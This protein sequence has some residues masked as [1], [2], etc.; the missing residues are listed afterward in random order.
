[1]KLPKTAILML[2]G[3]EG[4]GVSTYARHFKAYFDSKNAKCDIFALNLKIGRPDTSTDIDVEIF[5]FCEAAEMVRRI[6]KDYD[7][8]LVFS[9]PSKSAPKVIVENYVEFLLEP[10]T[11][12]KWMIN[13]DHHFLSIS[14]NADYA[15][16][17]ETCDGLLCH[18]LTETKSGFIS[19]LK[20]RNISKVAKKMDVF[21]HVPF[22]NHLIDLDRGEKRQKR[23][24]NAARAVAWKRGSVVLNLHNALADRGFVTEM[25]G[26]ER[27]IAGYSQLKNYEGKLKWFTDS[28]FYKPI[29]G[30]SA[31]SSARI[32]NELFDHIDQVGQNPDFMYVI[33]S[34]DYERGLQ[35]IS[36]SA[37]ATHPRSFEH[38]N[39]DYGNNFE[40]QGLEAALLAVPIFHRHFLDTVVL[41]DG[42]GTLAQTG[43]FLSVDDDN[44]HLTKGGPQV[45]GVEEFAGRLDEIWNDFSEYHRMR[46][47]SVDLVRSYY[48][49]D[50]V[51]P[52]LLAALS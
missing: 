43:V 8:V 25:I 9:V 14:R 28:S 3:V 39:L 26:F 30:P 23:L 33:G 7:L 32:N 4:C 5:A 38:N 15:N 46:K 34:Y 12:P 6:N 47:N 31:F 16:A 21:F 11:V 2:R 10:I 29:K 40:Y 49:S 18:S 13:H 42:S 24:I 22:V 52:K 20:K 19:W 51:V 35:R 36:E 17:I 37:F 45:L 50:V 44:R 41:P 1:M 48:S 27:S